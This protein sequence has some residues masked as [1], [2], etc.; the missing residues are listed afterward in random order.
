MS[1]LV[2]SQW[3]R[4]AAQ[5]TTQYLLSLCKALSLLFFNHVKSNSIVASSP[6][7]NQLQ[8]EAM[9]VHDPDHYIS[10]PAKPSTPTRW[11][12]HPPF[13][14]PTPFTFTSPQTKPSVNFIPKA[15]K[16]QP[17]HT[18]NLLPTSTPWVN[19]C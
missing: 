8:Q 2:T 14:F 18:F 1:S 10:A 17:N 9:F 15:T 3:F 4:L 7:T 5:S 12:L 11:S 13:P 19:F 6:Q 16:Q